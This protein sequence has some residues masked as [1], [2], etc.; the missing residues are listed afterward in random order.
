MK[1][2]PVEFRPTALEDIKGI[3]DYVLEKSR[4]GVTAERFTDRIFRQCEALGGMPYGGVARD[5]LDEGMR[6][7]PFERK[8]VIVYRIE[9]GTVWIVNVF[10]GGRDYEAIMRSAQ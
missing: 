4:D 6:I 2:F 1:I 8:A 10:A 7:F 3:F 5:D 9:N